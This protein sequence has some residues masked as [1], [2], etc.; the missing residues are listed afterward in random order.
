MIRFKVQNKPVRMTVSKATVVLS[1]GKHYEGPY[2]VTPKTTKQV[3]STA[4]KTLGA[5]IVVHPIPQEYGLVTY[6]QNRSITI[7]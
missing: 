4:G 2:E 1:G 6:D 5:D 7:S 3:L